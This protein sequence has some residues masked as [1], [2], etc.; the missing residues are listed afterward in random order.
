MIFT[1]N[2]AYPEL[3]ERLPFSSCARGLK[4]KTGPST[5]SGKSDFGVGGL[6]SRVGVVR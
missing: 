6:C 4:N 1:P 3:L 2:T 5:S